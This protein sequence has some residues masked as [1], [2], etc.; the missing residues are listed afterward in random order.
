MISLVISRPRHS[1][2]KSEEYEIEKSWL[3][4]TPNYIACR[5]SFASGIEGAA[6]GRV[7]LIEAATFA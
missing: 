5:V 1:E 3:T 4:R 2:G 6:P 7:T